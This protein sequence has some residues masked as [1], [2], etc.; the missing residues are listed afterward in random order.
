MTWAWSEISRALIS[1][2]HMEYQPPAPLTMRYSN[3]DTRRQPG[4]E[5]GGLR[6]MADTRSSHIPMNLMSHCSMEND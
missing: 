5:I 6:R 4:T 1:S 2:V 3:V